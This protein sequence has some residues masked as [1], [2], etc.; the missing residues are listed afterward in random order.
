MSIST[1]RKSSN[2]HEFF[3]AVTSLSKIGEG[4]SETLLVTFSFLWSS[5]APYPLWPWRTQGITGAP[6]SIRPWRASIT[7]RI[8]LPYG[9]KLWLPECSL[10]EQSGS[11]QI[12]SHEPSTHMDRSYDFL[13]ARQ[14]NK[15]AS[16]NILPWT[17]Q[18]HCRYG[19]NLQETK[20]QGLKFY[21]NRKPG[22]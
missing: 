19:Q 16:L 9:Q 17:R 1:I 4:G 3:V 15:L 10:I 18:G 11:V 7:A 21:K 14:S 8:L 2:E 12:F 6:C 13:S 5:E 22:T 20:T